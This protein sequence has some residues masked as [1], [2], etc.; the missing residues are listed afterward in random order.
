MFL[1]LDKGL[2]VIIYSE[3]PSHQW[4]APNEAESLLCMHVDVYMGIL[5]IQFKLQWIE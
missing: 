4:E 3:G 2:P 1:L 5:L